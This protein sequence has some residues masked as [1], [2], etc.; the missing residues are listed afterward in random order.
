LGDAKLVFASDEFA[1]PSGRRDLEFVRDVLQP[2]EISKIKKGYTPTLVLATEGSVTVTPA[3]G[4]AVTL[5]QGEAAS[6][7]AAITVKADGS[8]KSVL[9]AAVVGAAT[10]PISNPQQPTAAP[11]PTEHPVA[12]GSVGIDVY[13][14]PE[15]TG[16]A[17]FVPEDCQPAPDVASWT[18]ASDLLD[19]DLTTDDGTLEDG[20]LFWRGLPLGDYTVSPD[21]LADG[22]D[23]D[24]IRASAAV[25]R[26][27]D[28]TTSVAIDSSFPKIV[29]KAYVFPAAQ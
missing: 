3:A 4:E 13:A 29:L 23:D 24:Y 7:D 9:V 1:A 27:E 19:Q 10:K 21:E 28:G 5:K 17:N 8:R 14:C 11:L 6:F 26:N 18:L 25:A 12:T 20:T 16:I 15:S 22:Y 2:K